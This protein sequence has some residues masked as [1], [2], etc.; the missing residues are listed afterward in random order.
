MAVIQTHIPVLLVSLSA[1]IIEIHN[2]S[3]NRASFKMPT[4]LRIGLVDDVMKPCPFS[5][6]RVAIDDEQV[7]A[8]IFQNAL[9]KSGMVQRNQPCIVVLHPQSHFASDMTQSELQMLT[10]MVHESG[11]PIHG[12]V[13]FLLK[14][15]IDESDWQ[16]FEAMAREP[17]PQLMQPE[18]QAGVLRRAWNWLA[19]NL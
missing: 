1:G 5:H 16:Y 2:M 6:P 7:A 15:S 10:R 3:N 9:A 11:F 19:Q 12:E 17:A 14:P 18:N 8:D 13:Y 4:T